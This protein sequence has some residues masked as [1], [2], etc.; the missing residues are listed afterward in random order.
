MI[1]I[2]G[3]GESGFGAAMLAK[4]NAIP[5]F[6]SDNNVINQDIKTQLI[7][8]EIDF[9]ENGHELVYDISP[10]YVVKSP[11]IPN[12]VPV[13]NYFISK[14]IPIISEIEF[15][16][17]FCNGKIIAITGSNGKTT[18]TNLLYHLLFS[19]GKKVVKSGNVGYSFCK[20][21]AENAYDYFVLELS[22]FQLD[23][24]KSFKP[25]IAAIL[26]ITPDHLDRYDYQFQNY[27]N[28]KFR[29]LKN[30][31]SE[32]AF[33]YLK[34]DELISSNLRDLKV[35]TSVKAVEYTFDKNAE[36]LTLS[37]SNFNLESSNLKGNH[38]AMNAAIA[39]SIAL[40]LNIKDEVLQEGLNS[41]VNDPHRLEKVATINGVDYINDSKAT[42]VDS[43]FWALDAM[44]KK[45][46]WIV[47]GQDKGNDYSVLLPL[48]K[49][50]VKAIVGLGVDNSKI[51][52]YFNPYIKVIVDTKSI[53]D[54]IEYS[55][56]LAENGDVVLLSP[57]CA[58]FDLF[59]NYMDRGD[60]FKTIINQKR[61]KEW[62]Q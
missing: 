38:N 7:D 41:F 59:K 24:I 42:N 33:Y 45:I 50:K 3:C 32:D 47:G 55:S 61:L 36:V 49:S 53:N 39:L 40:D 4:Q 13:V 22:S 54:A 14:G 15:G 8:L 5:V 34:N 27:I 18:T 2:L 43:T 44:H 11:G 10:Q 52:S 37:N 48:V 21:I 26:N 51:I 20:A 25:N 23:D 1:V 46:V 12:K 29:I 9:E 57:A 35:R 58:S 56:Q 28:S 30:Q 16:Y 62:N 6:I 31:E 60:Q 17:Q 19:A